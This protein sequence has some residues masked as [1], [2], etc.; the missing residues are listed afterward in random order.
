MRPHATF[1]C[2][3]KTLL[4]REWQ[5]FKTDLRFPQCVLCY[6][7]LATYG[8]PFNHV[9]APV[10]QRQTPDMCDYSDALKEVAYI[11]YKD[12]SLRDKVFQKL[13]DTMP[14]N[15]YLYKRYITK[16]SGGGL[17]GVYK[18]LDAYLHVREENGS[19]A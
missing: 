11:I 19:L 5:Q 14:C 17:L 13:G 6:F 1:R 10:G 9:R 18:V 16:S 2:P 8:P 3:N 7:C 15:L 12:A 4:T